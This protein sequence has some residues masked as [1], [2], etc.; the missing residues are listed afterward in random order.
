MVELDLEISGLKKSS[1]WSLLINKAFKWAP[2]KGGMRREGSGVL[3]R[4]RKNSLRKRTGHIVVGRAA[5]LDLGIT[6]L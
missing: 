6:G 3:Y 4:S 2:L 5:E 1:A